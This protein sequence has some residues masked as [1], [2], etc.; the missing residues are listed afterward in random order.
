MFVAFHILC[1]RYVVAGNHD[2]DGNVLYQLQATNTEEHWKFPSLYYSQT[3][4]AGT[5]KMKIIFID[6]SNLAQGVLIDRASL[7]ENRVTVDA[8]TKIHGIRSPK[9]AENTA[10]KVNIAL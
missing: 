9:T 1:P 3:F 2:H 4:V 5:L 8:K 6:T 10:G 7:E